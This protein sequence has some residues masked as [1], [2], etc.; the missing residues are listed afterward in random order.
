LI[1]DSRLDPF[2]RPFPLLTMSSDLLTAAVLFK[3]DPQLGSVDVNKWNPK[4]TDEQLARTKKALEGKGHKVTVV[5]NGDEALEAIKS[6]IPAGSKVHNGASITL[7]EI[8][9]TDYFKKQTAWVNLHAQIL[10]ESDPAKQGELRRAANVCDYFLSSVTAVSEDGVLTV[11]D[12]TG[13]RVGPF[14]HSAAHVIAVAGSNK[15]VANEEAAKAR[16]EQYCLAVE[17]ARVR[18]AYKIP[19]SNITNY[20]AIK[21]A[22]PWSAPR[23]HVILIKEHFGY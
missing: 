22:A 3:S 13:T 4:V 10:A 12:L 6:S 19:N 23:F 17:S 8:G 2:E 18:V 7:T 16:T 20:V 5:A 9:F 15:I 14:T 1:L 21:Q 11:A